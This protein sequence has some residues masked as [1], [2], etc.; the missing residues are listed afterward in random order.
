MPSRLSNQHYLILL[1]FSQFAGT[2][3][4]FAGNAI[5]DQISTTDSGAT[6][7]SYVQFGFIAGTLLFSLLT[8]AD[9]FQAKNVFFYSS[10]LAAVAN[11]LIILLYKDAIAVKLLRFVTGFFLAG[12][13]PVGMKI[14]ADVFPQQ[15]GKA[16]GWLVGALVLGTSFPHFVRSGLENIHWETVITTT[17]LLALS[18]G[19]LVLLFIPPTRK[20]GVTAKPDFSVA[21]T[22]FRNP[23]FRSAAFGYFGHMWELYAFWSIL[24]LL[25]TFHNSISGTG[26]NV[27]WWS[28]LVIGTG[29]A[30]CIAGGF[31]SQQW[32][33]KKVAATALLL[34]GMSCLLFP[35]VFHTTNSLFY[36]LMLF[37]GFTVTADSP[38][39][40]ALVAKAAADKNKGTALTIV[41]SV[42]FAITIVSI[43]LLKE[44]FLLQQ[45][46]ALWLL[47]PGPFLGLLALRKSNPG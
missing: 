22:V 5:V 38:Q 37:W 20:H 16:L 2:S 18:G 35:F 40:S 14:A 6:I 46:K 11:A 27:F 45:E 30:G 47:A 19:V 28:F 21:F 43:L 17:S 29:S 26:A 39:F 9:R 23:S 10:L 25:F 32:G 1:V 4:W 36:G 42:G 13:Y 8:V 3:L 15:L 33:S 12:I 41:T 7:T 24:P 34:S 44:L 31:L